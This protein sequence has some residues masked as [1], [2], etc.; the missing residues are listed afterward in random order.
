MT[1]RPTSPSPTEGGRAERPAR[2]H[3]GSTRR[4]DDP[5]DGLEPPDG[6]PPDDPVWFDREHQQVLLRIESCDT[7]RDQERAARIASA[8]QTERIQEL[9]AEEAGLGSDEHL[10][11]IAES[12]WFPHL[13]AIRRG[14]NLCWW[15]DM[16]LWMALAVS[17]WFYC[18]QLVQ[19]DDGSTPA[20]LYLA[21]LVLVPLFASVC[22]RATKGMGQQ[23]A[24]SRLTDATNIEHTIDRQVRVAGSCAVF[25]LACLLVLLISFLFTIPGGVGVVQAVSTIVTI[26]ANVT[27]GLAAGIGSNAAGI[28]E[29]PS[30]RE[31]IRCRIEM[32]KNLRDR[33]SKFFSVLAVIASGLSAA[34]GAEPAPVWVWLV[35][36]TDLEPIQRRAALDALVRSATTR[37]R[38]LN[39]GAIQVV[40]ITGEDILSNMRW[41]VV[42]RQAYFEDCAKARPATAI[43]KTWTQWSPAVVAEHR[44]QAVAACTARVREQRSQALAEEQGFRNALWSAVSA[45]PRANATRIVPLLNLVLSRPGTRAV[46]IVSTGVDQSGLPLMSLSVPATTRVTLILTRPDPRHRPYLWDVLQAGKA[47]SRVKGVVVVGAEEYAGVWPVLNAGSLSRN[48]GSE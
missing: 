11:R 37:A 14:A 3:L 42:P 39:V 34:R 24:V 46:D 15:F 40:T 45:T 28:L 4:A 18:R 12:S 7:R 6:D 5:G 31:T 22:A 33:L 9:N 19:A 47:W 16:L 25:G 10:R 48:T 8:E 29:K 2:P 27:F 36:T 41:V 38:Q 23:V 44:A 30:R 35:G 20:L 32:K 1:A 43:G 17:L 26:G 13:R 21:G